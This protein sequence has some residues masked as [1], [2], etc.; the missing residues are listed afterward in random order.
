[1]ATSKYKQNGF[2]EF[3]YSLLSKK[4]YIKAYSEWY[5]N[6]LKGE[7]CIFNV[8]ATASAGRSKTRI[9]K[10]Q[11]SKYAD[12]YCQTVLK[13]VRRRLSSSN[14]NNLLKLYDYYYEHEDKLMYKD[15]ELT[16]PHHIHGLLLFPIGLERKIWITEEN[17]PS[18]RLMRDI[19]ST[20]AFSDVEIKPI[21]NLEGWLA[22][23]TKR[24]DH[25]DNVK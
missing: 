21:H 6:S 15:D 19:R 3:Y 22:Y 9:I 10:A 20:K 4:E 25:N 17:Q 2:Q 7:M 13:K 5:E 14:G 23:M 16:K 24:K 12:L 18:D 8:T 11:P 1:M